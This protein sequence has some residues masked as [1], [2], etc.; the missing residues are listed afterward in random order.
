MF[1][2]VAYCESPKITEEAFLRRE[3]GITTIYVSSIHDFLEKSKKSDLDSIVIVSTNPLFW[4]TVL[5][6]FKKDSVIFILIG[7]ETYDPR[8]F[9]LLNNLK[10]LRHAFVYNLPTSIKAKNLFGPIIGNIIDGGLAKTHNKGSVYRD[11]RISY[12]LINKFRNIK[13]SYSCSRF[14]QGYSNNFASKMGVRIGINENESLLDYKLVTSIMKE[15]KNIYDFAFIGQPTNRRREIFLKSVKRMSKSIIIYNEEFK[16]IYEDTDF[17]YLDQLLSARFILVPPGFY[18]NSN[19]RYTESLICN[20]IPVIL[21]NNSLDPSSN[22]NWTND[23][24]YINRYSVKA[25]LRYLSKIDRNLY[26][27]IYNLAKSSD[28]GQIADTKK[29]IF[30]IIE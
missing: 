11:A 19:H 22:N 12:S 13:I 20:T 1:N 9:N 21:A 28:F 24:F 25:Q 10:S 14:P 8:V 29:L 5:N 4:I 3:F 6:K 16:G 30:E 27:Q 26:N 15:R 23:L 18:N 2:K 17:K 7:N